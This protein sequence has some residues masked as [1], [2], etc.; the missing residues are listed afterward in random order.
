MAPK[1]KPITEK[2]LA[3]VDK[4][5]TRFHKKKSE[6]QTVRDSL[7][8]AIRAAKES[9]CTYRDIASSSGLSIAWIQSSLYRA[10]YKASATHRSE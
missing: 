4:L 8:D 3:T 7:D 2:N 6:T 10:G 1:A 9:G 5:A